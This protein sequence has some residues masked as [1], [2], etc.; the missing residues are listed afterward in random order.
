MKTLLSSLLVV[1]ASSVFGPN[2]LGAAPTNARPN[3]LFILTDD[4]GFSDIGPHGG[5][6]Q[7]PNLDRLAA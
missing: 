7:T 2:L 5:E 1:A 6:I 4:M 3:I